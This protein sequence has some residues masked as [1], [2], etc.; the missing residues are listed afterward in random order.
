MKR[1]LRKHAPSR[2][3]LEGS[4]WLRPLGFALARPGVWHLNR[5]SAA[6]GVAIGLLTGLMPGPTQILSAA[7][8]SVVLRANLPAAVLTTLYTNPVTIVPI[9][10][11]AYQIGARVTGES[12]AMPPLPEFNVASAGSFFTDMG[13][14]V[15]ALG[16]TLLIGL[17]LQGWLS[18][19]LGYLAVV[20]AWRWSVV[21]RWRLRKSAA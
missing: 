13:T 10:W 6:L 19:C 9:Y 12:G 4:R 1:W 11:L 5:R 8:L 21:R 15:W 3:L 7:F 17:L 14:W 18:A 2:Q 16:D 20:G